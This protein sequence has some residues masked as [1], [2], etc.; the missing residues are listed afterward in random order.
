M[1]QPEYLYESTMQSRRDI[2]KTLSLGATGLTALPSILTRDSLPTSTASKPLGIALVGLGNYSQAALKPALYETQNVKLA[3]IVTGTPEKARAWSEEFDLEERHIYNYDTFDRIA[4]DEAIDIIYIVLP[5]FMHAEYTIRALEAGKHVICE[6]PMGMNTA[7]CEAM[8][9]ASEE[10]GRLLSVGYRLHYE[11]HHREAM[12]LGQEKPFGPINF[13]EAGLAYHLG[14]PTLWR[15]NR[16]EGGGGAIMDLGVYPIQACRYV[17]GEEPL[18]VTAQAFV[19]DTSR[20]KGI[21][22]SFFWQFEFPSGLLAN[23]TTSYSSYVD[24]LHISCYRGWM[25]LRPSFGGRGTSGSTS[26]GP[27][28][29]GRVNQ[30]ALHMD[31]F[32]T[33][34]QESTPLR[35]TAQEG[36]QDLRLI[37]AIKQAI[38]SGER[39]VV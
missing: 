21:Y 24:R 17:S 1:S 29:L 10:A 23:C 35:V 14:D 27:M 19:R 28:K 9:A 4:D 11:N 16:D 13:I 20:F 33:S 2:L 31:D 30:Q 39:V 32:A 15:L 22:E 12:R 37:D 26:N 3:G 7:E 8:I 5:N 6:K 34:I 25:E 18:A 38:E 36:L